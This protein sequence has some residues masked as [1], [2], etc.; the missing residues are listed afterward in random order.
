MV[1]IW[2]QPEGPKQVGPCLQN[3][4]FLY[5][6]RVHEEYDLDWTLFFLEAAPLLNTLHIQVYLFLALKIYLFNANRNSFISHIEGWVH[7]L[8]KKYHCSTLFI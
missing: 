3:L 4:R 8:W 5:L 6:Q 7:V 2:I 1:Q